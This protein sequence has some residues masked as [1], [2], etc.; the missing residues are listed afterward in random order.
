M[1]MLWT[2]RWGCTLT[3]TELC[4]SRVCKGPIA[5][6]TFSSHRFFS[7]SLEGMRL[8]NHICTLLLGVCKPASSSGHCKQ[9]SGRK[10][11][12][13]ILSRFTSLNLH[14]HSGK[15]SSTGYLFTTDFFFNLCWNEWVYL[16]SRK[17]KAT[18]YSVGFVLP[19]KQRRFQPTMMPSRL[20]K[21]FSTSHGKMPCS[22]F[23]ESR[24]K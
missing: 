19:C 4:V 6:T 24:H 14:W 18:E 23:R 2:W 7:Y 8:G 15:R 1:G 11:V 20:P 22:S 3:Y 21:M 12:V 10:S 17:S 5:T 9:A 13:S 16:G